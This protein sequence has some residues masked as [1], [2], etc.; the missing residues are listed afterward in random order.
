MGRLTMPRNRSSRKL[1]PFGAEW[2]CQVQLDGEGERGTASGNRT[3]E[4]V[5]K[6]S[7]ESKFN[8]FVWNDIRGHEHS[9]RLSGLTGSTHP[10]AKHGSMRG[11]VMMGVMRFVRDGLCR[12]ESSDSEQAEDQQDGERLLHQPRRHSVPHDQDRS[13]RWYPTEWESVKH[14]GSE[15]IVFLIGF[16]KCFRYTA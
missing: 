15:P 5:L 3:G 14:E 4:G 7:F 13:R 10:A 8:K 2:I 12:G 11:L 6:V 16:R 9:R 1:I